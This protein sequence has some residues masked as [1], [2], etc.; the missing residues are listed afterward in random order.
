M[1]MEIEEIAESAALIDATAE[2]AAR[3]Y[4][5][6]AVKFGMA[7]WPR[8][9][10]RKSRNWSRFEQI[11]RMCILHKIPVEAFVTAAFT[12]AM[13]RHS[14]VTV[15]DVCM[16]NPD[17]L[18]SGSFDKGTSCPQDLWNMLS[19]KLI[20]MLFAIDG[21]KGTQ[22][23]LDSSMYGFPAWFRVFSPE[24][25]PHDIIVHWGDIAYE[26]MTEN[27]KLHEY[28]KKKRPETYN[29]LKSVVKNI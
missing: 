29:L 14:L 28:L 1:G 17:N 7:K 2:A 6:H 8:Y 24:K 19:C 16:F 10:L 20:D 22:E 27:Q 26:E 25:P 21:V 23:L 4:Y 18:T 5:E 12:R 15:G 9:G 3:T 13:E 11:A